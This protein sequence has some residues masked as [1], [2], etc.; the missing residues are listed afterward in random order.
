MRF[1]GLRP[2]MQTE[3]ITVEVVLA[4]PDSQAMLEVSIPEGAVVAEA[5]EKSGIAARFP[6]LDVSNL[7]PGV[8]GNVVSRGH[9]LADGDRVELYRP[10]QIDPREARRQLAQSGRTMRQADDG[11]AQSPGSSS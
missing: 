11:D 8:W 9:R 10:L 5:I 4:M 6:Q 2:A 3:Q 1:M 7:I